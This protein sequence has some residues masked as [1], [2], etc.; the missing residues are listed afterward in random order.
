[1]RLLELELRNVKA[2]PEVTIAFGPGING[3]LGPNGA[4]KTTILQAIGYALFNCLSPAVKDFTREGHARGSIRVRMRSARDDLTYD[5]HRTVG[6]GGGSQNYVYNCDDDFKVHE[7]ADNVLAFVQEHLGSPGASDMKTLFRDAVGIDQGTFQA[8]FLMGAAPRKD[9]FGPLLGIEKYRRIDTDLNATRAYAQGLVAESQTR[10]DHLDGQLEPLE[11][12]VAKQEE[13]QAT[14]RALEWETCMIEKKREDSLARLRKLDDLAQE[15]QE[16]NSLLAEAS[17]ERA[18][19]LERSKSLE[20]ELA[21]VREAVQQVEQYEQA[22][23]LYQE[24]EGQL[25]PLETRVR[26]CHG[27]QRKLSLL[28]GEMGPLQNQ[29]QDKRERIADLHRLQIRL[30]EL[31]SAKEEEEELWRELEQCP[32][33]VG[34]IDALQ[35]TLASLQRRLQLDKT[36]GEHIKAEVGARDRAETRLAEL[37]SL[38]TEHANDQQVL[39]L[40]Q[41]SVHIQLKSLSEQ[42]ETL[43]R[44]RQDHSP[45]ARCPVCEQ[46]LNHDL[47]STLTARREA[48]IEAKSKV[49][50]ELQRELAV[51]IEAQE[52]LKAECSALRREMAEH[53]DR[54]DLENCLSRIELLQRDIDGKSRALSKA[55]ELQS[56]RQ[57]LQAELDVLQPN[58][59]EWARAHRALEEQ[60]RLQ[61]DLGKLLR[62]LQ[63]KESEAAKIAEDVGQVEALEKTASQLRLQ[64]EANRE[65]YLSYVAHAAAA[66][67]LA[68]LEKE[69]SQLSRQTKQIVQRLFEL[70][71][72]HTD[73]KGQYEPKEHIALQETTSRLKAELAGKNATS[74]AQRQYL[75]DVS[76]DVTRL[77]AVARSRTQ[78]R[79]RLALLE[80]REERVVW[81][82]EL[83]RRALPQI[84]AALIQ[85]ISELANEFFCSLMEDHT[86]PLQWDANFGI[87]LNVK[88]EERQFRNL[89]GGEQ[90]AAS[91]SVIMALL[92][93]LSNIR[94]V[95][96]DEPTSNLDG[97]RRGQLASNLK[98]LGRIEQIF[99]IS[100]DDTFEEHLDHVIRLEAGPEGSRVVTEG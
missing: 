11:S 25:K 88:G 67:G 36:A 10:L 16:V 91:L 27:L 26:S 18:R 59:E 70:D 19:L 43:Q 64:R 96:L 74:K 58:L 78:E 75:E 84:T 24:A 31:Q 39:E 99:V 48:E 60:P 52:L 30:D 28:Q 95:F 90:M 85:N 44:T 83:M 63:R 35:D 92:H 41:N 72:R 29:V 73:L 71:R 86:R 68:D 40:R 33:Q 80:A 57:Q 1:M 20:R 8:P 3:L 45:Q 9:H 97:V 100:H 69:S 4:G 47:V 98:T 21:R 49:R 61:K 82:K 6:G 76:K 55:E 38:Q 22:H 87:V 46:G 13:L 77:R 12:L 53:R 17:L 34:H 66:Q 56:D 42:L 65:G 7:G 15:I 5:I 14:V 50:D 79:Q 32:S 93:R 51:T 81:L 2:Y 89:S 94:F 37:Q 62:D 54:R 23:R